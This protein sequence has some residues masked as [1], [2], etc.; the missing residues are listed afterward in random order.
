MAVKTIAIG[1]EIDRPTWS[2]IGFD[3]ARELSKYYRVKVFSKQGVPPCDLLILI[4][5]ILPEYLLDLFNIQKVIYFP[6]DHYTGKE[7]MENERQFLQRCSCLVSQSQRLAD[8]LKE[9]NSNVFLVHHSG[10]YIL[11]TM[12]PYRQEGF[13]LW[14]GFSKYLRYLKAWL[15]EHPIENELVIL[16]DQPAQ[17]FVPGKVKQF[18]WDARIQ[19]EMMSQAK[20]ALDIKGDDFNQLNRPAEKTQIF[21]ASGIPAACNPGPI[22]TFLKESGF[23]IVSPDNMVRWFSREYYEETVKFGEKLREEMS[24]LNVG[25]EVKKII[26]GL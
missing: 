2:W 11:P 18:R 6:C 17:E 19:F 14:V 15:Q 3:L 20:A 26:E 8:I 24:L 13:I 22:V 16:T 23:D 25:L 9:Y 4:K 10:K 5:D 7:A 1:P 21:I 12:N